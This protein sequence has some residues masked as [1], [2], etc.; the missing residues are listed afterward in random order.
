[1][2]GED[3]GPVFSL[4]KISQF[5]SIFYYIF[6]FSPYNMLILFLIYCLGFMPQVFSSIVELNWDVTWVSASPD[7]FTRPVV[8]INNQFP[9]PSIDVRYT[10]HS[11]LVYSWQVQCRSTWAT[12]WSFIWQISL[13][14]RQP[15]CT[16]MAYIKLELALWTGPLALHNVQSPLERR[17][18]MILLH[19]HQLKGR[20]IVLTRR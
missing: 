19:V 5:L 3:K 20:F 18:L 7:G 17:L 11:N 10:G 6:A 9:C 1:M 13:A 8:G 4:S 16:S 12:V 2:D 14:T 15:P